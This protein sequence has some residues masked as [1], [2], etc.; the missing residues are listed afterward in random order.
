MSADVY[1][2]AQ[3]MK[4]PRVEEED[5]LGLQNV[6]GATVSGGKIPTYWRVSNVD[7]VKIISYWFFYG[8]QR[9]CLSESDSKMTIDNK[10]RHSGRHHGDWESID[11]RLTSDESAVDAVVFKQHGG[12]VGTRVFGVIL[13]SCQVKK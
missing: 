4:D 12:L 6:D 1:R 8:L 2:T 3:Y 10:E 5:S 11:V 9:S 7:G 13:K